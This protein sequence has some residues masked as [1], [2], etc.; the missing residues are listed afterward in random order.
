MIKK[1]QEGHKEWKKEH[2]EHKKNLILSIMEKKRRLSD[3]LGLLRVVEEKLNNHGNKYVNNR[4][5][6]YKTAVG[7]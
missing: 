5:D 7:D 2:Q 3:S 4:F 6:V 1:I